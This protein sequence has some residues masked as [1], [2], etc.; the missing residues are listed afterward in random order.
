M[1]KTF[2]GSLPR[3]MYRIA[4]AVIGFETAI[5]FKY[6]PASKGIE[7]FLVMPRYS[8]GKG[9]VSKTSGRKA[10]GVQV[11]SSALL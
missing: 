10:L 4:K 6:L 3:L 9:L 7:Y 5:N 2:M 8:N 11:S 1:I